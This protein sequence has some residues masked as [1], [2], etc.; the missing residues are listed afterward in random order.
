M[1]LHYTAHMTNRVDKFIAILKLERILNICVDAEFGG[2]GRSRKYHGNIECTNAF[3]KIIL[4]YQ[5]HLIVI[6]VPYMF[7]SEWVNQ[8]CYSEMVFFPPVVTGHV[9]RPHMTKTFRLKLS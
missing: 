5:R 3:I 2:V 8:G 1:S 4:K 7:Y 6:R 9:I